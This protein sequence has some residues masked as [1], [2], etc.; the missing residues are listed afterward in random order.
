MLNNP[1]DGVCV[2]SDNQT[3]GIGSRENNWVGQKGN[4]FF[5][6]SFSKSKLPNDVPLQSVSIY[7]MY[8]MK[9]VLES[10]GSK[11]RFKWPN[12]LYIKKKV[13]GCITNVKND[14][15]IVGIGI[16]TKD[17][18]RFGGLDV[19]VENK[20]VIDR[21][22]SFLK[23][24]KKWSEIFELFK[25]EFYLGNFVTSDGVRLQD[26][27]LDKDGSIISNNERIYSLR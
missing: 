7:F 1:K 25:K 26:C 2:W 16:N 10:F 9:M 18:G 22:F 27:F 17:G 20:E 8:Q 23:A 19:N 6:F 15:I 14:I 3:H 12:D 21:Y 13:G 5:S 24:K 4:L 11:V